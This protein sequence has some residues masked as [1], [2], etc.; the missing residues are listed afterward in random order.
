MSSEVKSC[1]FG[2]VSAQIGTCISARYV[3]QSNGV[4]EL[5]ILLSCGYLGSLCFELR[6]EVFA[7]SCSTPRKLARAAD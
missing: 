1:N 4:Q 7:K 3:Q 6:T 2:G 5:V